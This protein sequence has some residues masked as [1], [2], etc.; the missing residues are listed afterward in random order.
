MFA[1][2]YDIKYSYLIIMIIYIQ[3]FSSNYLIRMIIIIARELKKTVE[4]ESD[5]YTN[6]D[7]CFWYSHQRTIKGT[8]GLGSKRMSGGH[9]NYY[10]IENSQNIEETCCHSNSNERSSA[11]ADMKNSQGVNNNN[12]ICPGE[13]QTNS[14]GI[15][16]YK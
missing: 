8:G 12:N 10:I 2:L 9:P 5:N 3:L 6:C 1:Q 14:S 7:W 4:H 15:W 16:T 11:N 13:W